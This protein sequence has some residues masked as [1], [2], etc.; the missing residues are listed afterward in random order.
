MNSER[1]L[2][3]DTTYHLMWLDF[4]R[5]VE[6]TS[7]TTGKFFGTCSVISSHKDEKAWVSIYKFI[8][9]CG[10]NPRYNIGDGAKA[11]TNASK[12]VFANHTVSRLMCWSHVHRNIVPRLK[13]IATIDKSL[14]EK[15]LLNIMDIQW[16]SLNKA[17]FLKMVELLEQKY[18]GKHEKNL[19]ALIREFF[20]YLQKV[21]ISS[22][23]NKWYEGAHPWQVSNN[24][25]VEGCNKEI[26]Q[27]HTFRRRLDIGE[28]IPVL[29][30]LVHEWSEND[31]KLLENSRLS[32]LDGEILSLALKTKGYQWF[33]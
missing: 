31:E 4:P 26:K 28:L 13:S 7:S 14:S 15:I 17:T 1:V 5:F 24:Q 19:D 16:S 20:V 18:V 11:I 33:I 3:T 12:N 6:G 30:R 29:S 9:S 25:G 23:K 21:W 27:S 2:Q 10:I 32:L 22:G 8:Q